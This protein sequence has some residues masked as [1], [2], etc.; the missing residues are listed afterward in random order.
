MADNFSLI[1]TDGALGAG[2]PNSG[3]A[4]MLIGT[5]PRLE[6]PVLKTV[7]IAEDAILV[8]EHRSIVP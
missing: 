5:N 6:A 3:R 1:V 2:A 8:G 4:I 7:E